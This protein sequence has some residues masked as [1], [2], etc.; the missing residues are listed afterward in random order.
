MNDPQSTRAETKAGPGTTERT[1]QARL[2][3]DKSAEWNVHRA[4]YDSKEVRDERT[5]DRAFEE[6][7]ESDARNLAAF[8]HPE[9]RVVDLGCGIGRV[10]RP[11]APLCREIV[12]IDISEKMIQKGREF[13]ANV[14]NARLVHTTGAEIPSVAN[15]SVDF[16]FSLICLI[17][18]DKRTAFRYLREIERVLTPSGMVLLQFENLLSPE[19][20]A[21]FQR[22]IDLDIEY[23]LEFYTR[24]EIRQLAGAVGLKVLN[25]RE[26]HQFLFATLTRAE[27]ADWIRNVNEGVSI[28]LGA[29]EGIFAGGGREGRIVAQAETTLPQPVALQFHGVLVPRDAAGRW[30][31]RLGGQVLLRPGKRHTLEV[32]HDA[33]GSAR[34]LLDG[35]PLPLLLFQQGNAPAEG[36]VEF[37]ASL[38]PP[39]FANEAETARLFPNLY[40]AHP[41]PG[42]V[43]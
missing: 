16:L 25:F 17:H 19:G 31:Y 21:E 39:G 42:M 10:M 22:V 30:I 9:G 15:G 28:A 36:P 2:F 27:P 40:P 6:S 8:V 3:W 37:M 12:G 34:C 11:L 26:D 7:G 43:G 13:L 14:S 4:I 20:L 35:Q 23:P 24:E 18:V 38:T 41:V 5:R 29:A 32:R 33:N 1:R